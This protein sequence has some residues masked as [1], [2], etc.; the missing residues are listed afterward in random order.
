MGW[1][2]RKESFISFYRNNQEIVAG[3]VAVTAFVIALTVMFGGQRA[4]VI[5]Y[6]EYTQTMYDMGLSYTDEVQQEEASLR[7]VTV[8][9][10]FKVEKIQL[11]GLLQLEPAQSLIYPVSL[12]SIMCKLLH[13]PFSTQYLAILFF[14]ITIACIYSITRSAYCFFKEKAA[15]IGLLCTFVFLCGNYTVYFNSLYR[16]GIYFV[17]FLVFFTILFHIAASKG[18]GQGKSIL[19]LLFVSLLLLNARAVNIVYLPVVIGANLWAMIY[20]RPEKRKRVSYYVVF[21]VLLIFVVRSNV[22][23]T[24]QNEALFSDT[25]M[26]HSFLTGALMQSEDKEEILRELSLDTN[27]TEDIGKNAYLPKE[28]YVIYPYSEEAKTEIFSYLSYIQL[29]KLYQEH[30]SLYLN[31]LK[32]TARHLIQIDTKR[33]LAV[34]RQ[35]NVGTE[36][37]ERFVWWQWIRALL[38]PRS[39][40]GYG[41]FAC[42]VFALL[43][44]LYWLGKSRENHALALIGLLLWLSCVTQFLTIYAWQG[45]AEA[46]G[47]NYY[48]IFTFDM[49]LLFFAG[50]LVKG[51]ERAVQWWRELLSA[52]GEEESEV[53]IA[54]TSEE[55][56][57]VLESFKQAEELFLPNPFC[58]AVKEGLLCAKS[59]CLKKIFSNTN[60]SA[61]V[62]AVAAAIIVT[63]VLFLP[64]RIG[65]YNNGD[66]G[67]MMTAMNIQY[68]KEDWEN[69]D[70]LS[71]TKVV[72][73]YDWVEPYDYRKVIP[74][75]GELSQIWFSVP[76][77]IIDN[78]V[79]LS[80]STV[81][82]T[83]IYAVLIV[84]SIFFIMQFLFHR[85]G[86]KAFWFAMV[87][88][89]VLLDLVNLGWLNSLFGEG[90]AYVSLLMVIASALK[91]ADSKRG[92]CRFSF[93]ILIFSEILFIGAKAQYTIATPVLI[94]GTFVLFWYHQPSK[95]W[96]KIL[97]YALFFIGSIWLSVGAVH[98]YENNSGISSPDTIYQ[99]VF[100]G[101]LMLVEDPAKT[102]TELGLDPAMAV[103]TG[104]HAYLPK[105]AYY[106]PPR[107][108]KAEEML[109]TKI[110][111]ADLFLYYLKHP[112]LLY[113]SMEITA[114]AAALDMPDYILLVGQK[115]TQEHAKVERF[116]IWGT[117]RSYL[118]FGHF[119]EV[120]LVFGLEWVL[121]IKFIWN[122]KRNSRDKML[123]FV[124]LMIS[125]VGILQYPLTFIGNGYADNTKQLYLYRFIYDLVVMTGIFLLVPRVKWFFEHRRLRHES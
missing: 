37:V 36:W 108:E 73:N 66:F 45:F 43:V 56:S 94:A 35:A 44:M 42:I 80:F 112:K 81:Y 85:F 12:I 15:A 64:S 1:K 77:K 96:K 50:F 6:G 92:S 13:I 107:T 47:T 22:R 117:I 28:S 31:V 93:L 78:M 53:E 23:Y 106:C 46:D 29:L 82:V 24:L 84:I 69:S 71:L 4:G 118:T 39:L 55:P 122:K 90:I 32:E 97:Y 58:Q 16:N 104:K 48:F 76:L 20:C 57:K 89:V 115:T 2:E 14:F 88:L 119:W 33:F 110:S 114:Q 86:V 7:Y 65:A 99:S 101:L 72:E 27:L 62:F 30:P 59:F 52:S 9:E 70:E 21:T 124:L 120:M 102:L 87:L 98:I 11:L 68:T 25:Q 83:A 10:T 100:Y 61:M 34:N 26:Y 116:H 5:D 19:M 51:G 109:Y 49:M 91:I 41:A 121:G 67:R 111:T 3:F 95:R 79:G 113:E 63:F 123:L 18:R 8:I 60:K 105:E 40:M 75:W 103:D 54:M 74:T 17:S 38:V 125:A